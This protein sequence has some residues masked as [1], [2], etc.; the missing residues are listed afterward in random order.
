MET[1]GKTR[2]YVSKRMNRAPQ[3]VAKPWPNET[4]AG[5]HARHLEDPI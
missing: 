5:T 1:H 2:K 3:G 4:I